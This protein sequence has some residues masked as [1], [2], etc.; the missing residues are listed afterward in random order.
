ML[1]IV[2]R[3]FKDL[4]FE[5][6]VSGCAAHQRERLLEEEIPRLAEL[7]R[8]KTFPGAVDER[9]KFKSNRRTCRREWRP[10]VV[11]ELSCYIPR[12]IAIKLR[13]I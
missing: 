3:N 6:F 12:C 1:P 10:L 11:T 2:R 4:V 7:L 8:V 9:D 13:F 5:C